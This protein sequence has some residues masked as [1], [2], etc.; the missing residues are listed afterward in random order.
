MRHWRGKG[1]DFD[2]NFTKENKKV[3]SMFKDKAK[4]KHVTEFIGLRSKLYCYDLENQ[5]AK[6]AKSITKSTIKKN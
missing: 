4:G 6:K 1:F 5:V 3:I 2:Y